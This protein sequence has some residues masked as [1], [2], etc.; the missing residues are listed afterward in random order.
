MA[1]P[2]IEGLVT[3]VL[4][5]EASA[6]QALWQAVEPRLYA[7]IR[8]PSFLGRLSESEDDC[9]NIVVEVL[10]ALR[11]HDHM[12]LRSFAAARVANPAL[13]FFAWLTVVAKRLAIDYMRRQDTYQD[14][15][16]RVG[17][18]ARGAWTPI[19]ALPPES[20]LPG[21]RPPMTNRAAVAELL[22]F[23]GRDL[24]LEQRAALSA[25][26]QGGSFDDVA[27]AAGLP[28]ARQA[29]RV[30]RAALERLRRRFRPGEAT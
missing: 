17:E 20:Q 9:R 10:A 14:L 7:L 5:G 13:P 24:P 8:R 29:E 12:R 2:N 25:W 1:P 11:A 18:G 19:T 27:R 4:A 3:R 28:S 26:L 22:T 6:W 16:A 15:R 30:V 21:F 23:A